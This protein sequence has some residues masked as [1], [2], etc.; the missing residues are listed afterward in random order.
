MTSAELAMYRDTTVD[1]LALR[2]SVD[3]V[4]VG[5]ESRYSAPRW[6][7]RGAPVGSWEWATTYTSDSPSQALTEAA[8]WYARRT[9]AAWML[10]LSDYTVDAC[11]DTLLRA[12]PT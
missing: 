4:R 5:R 3:C 8:E 11:R 9:L 6:D 2:I 12:H 7:A 1:G 10:G